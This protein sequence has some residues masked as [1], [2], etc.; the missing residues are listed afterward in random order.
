MQEK[1]KESEE[2]LKE[3]QAISEYSIIQCELEKKAIE[4]T[5]E[6]ITEEYCNLQEQHKQLISSSENLGSLE[7]TIDNRIN[8]LTKI[9]DE[10]EEEI[11]KLSLEIKTYDLTINNAQV[12]IEVLKNRLIHSDKDVEH[13]KQDLIRFAI[14]I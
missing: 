2:I 14:N 6:K 8:Q 1:E 4:N 9:I 13:L 5:L 7:K 3:C 12:T 10:K 11:R